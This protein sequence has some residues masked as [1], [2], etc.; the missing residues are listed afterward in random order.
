MRGSSRE[1]LDYVLRDMTD[2]AGGFYSTED[3]D[4]E[5]EE[6]KF[7]VWTPGEIEQVL[8]PDAA[9]T[10]CRVY[11][12]TEAGQFRGTQHPQ[13]AEDA[14][15]VRGRCSSRDTAEL[16]AEL[17]AGRAKL[18]AV[19]DRRVRPGRDDKVLV[20]LERPDDR[21]LGPGRGSPCDEPRIPGRGRGGRFHSPAICVGRD[22]RLLHSW[23]GGQAKLDAYLDDYACL[24]NALV[25]LYE[26]TFD[27]RYIDEA[28]RLVD[29]VLAQFA[30]PAGGGFFYT[31]ADHEQLIARTK[32]LHDS[33][34]PSGDG[35]GG[36]GAGAAGRISPGERTI[37]RR[38][39][40]RF[41]GMQR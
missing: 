30:D 28:V 4:S 12:V 40:R 21:R 35:D 38:P 25:S 29:V 10:F 26:A 23:R 36:D 20:E 2:P 34:V 14:R 13:P 8:G 16:A 17:A 27:E 6:G 32:D 9:E 1:T 19:R 15:T 24:I 39:R 31:A 3:A 37:K 18:L 22:G 11:D 5:G 33:S 7:Y 41:A